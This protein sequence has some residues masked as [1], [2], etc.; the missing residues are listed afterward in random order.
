MDTAPGPGPARPQRS[1]GQG[2]PP[3]AG[4]DR[5]PSV[6]RSPAL[7]GPWRASRPDTA[8]V[9][10]PAHGPSPGQRRTRRPSG[11]AARG[12]RAEHR[13]VA[14]HA[15]GNQRHHRT[16]GRNHD[17]HTATVMAPHPRATAIRMHQ[18]APRAQPAACSHACRAGHA[19]AALLDRLA[20]VGTDVIAFSASTTCALQLALRHPERVQAPGGDA[21]QLTGRPDRCPP[22]A[23]QSAAG[24]LRIPHVGPDDLRPPGQGLRRALRLVRLQPRRQQ[25][26]P[27]SGLGTDPDRPRPGAIR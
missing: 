19:Y 14:E 7:P 24:A 8:H 23:S 6:S 21:G 20:I 25:R 11:H 10:A 3:A 22:A 4:R 9:P 16:T 17:R 26:R 18:H 5:P 12:R 1:S 15:D 27:G 2:L 13:S